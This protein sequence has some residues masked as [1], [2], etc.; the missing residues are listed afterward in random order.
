MCTYMYPS[1]KVEPVFVLDV[2]DLFLIVWLA[3]VWGTSL[4]GDH[5]MT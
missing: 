2:K 5:Q 1:D 4:L 3:G